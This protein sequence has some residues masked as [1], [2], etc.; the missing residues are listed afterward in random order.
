MHPEQHGGQQ[1]KKGDLGASQSSGGQQGQ[2]K[3]EKVKKALQM[4]K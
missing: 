2:S 4:D 3:V 1:S